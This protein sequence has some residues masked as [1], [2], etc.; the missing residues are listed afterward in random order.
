VAITI[1]DAP[2]G[3]IKGVSLGVAGRRNSGQGIFGGYP[4]APSVL[5][6]IE[7]SHPER[8]MAEA[9]LPRDPAVLKGRCQSLSYCDFE[10]KKGDVLYIRAGSGGGYGDPLERDAGMVSRDV[11][12]GAV[13]RE[14]ARTI[15][16]VVV[17]RRGRLDTGLTEKLRDRTRKKRLQGAL[18]AKLVVE[19]NASMEGAS[20]PPC[21]LVEVWEEPGRNGMRCAR[22][23]GKLGEFGRNWREGCRVKG[24]RPT[25]AGPLMKDLVGY[26]VLR[27]FY[28][29]SCGTLL[30]TALA[31]TPQKTKKRSDPGKRTRKEKN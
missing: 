19:E 17:D 27:Q 29:P 25:E 22:C 7:G 20:Y 30:E 21:E 6:L 5:T 11:A 1:H 16:G 14:S 9:G 2:E 13:S 4:A 18:S 31:D 8:F 24:L 15:Y 23:K 3:K 26:F 28:C 12:N 10:L